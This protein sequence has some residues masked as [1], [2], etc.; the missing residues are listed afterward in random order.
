MNNNQRPGGRSIARRLTTRMFFA[1]LFS[2][3]S[4]FITVCI[5]ATISVTVLVENRA[6][7][8]VRNI[9][10]DSVVPSETITSEFTIT[11]VPQPTGFLIPR[12]LQGIFPDATADLFR[13]LRLID[14]IGHKAVKDEFLYIVY[15]THNDITYCISS[16]LSFTVRIFNGA[17]AVFAIILLIKLINQSI[18]NSRAI[19]HSLD[20]IT[21]LTRAAETLGRTVEKVAPRKSDVFAMSA[22]VGNEVKS[23]INHGKAAAV[24]A[25]GLGRDTTDVSAIKGAL[26]R[27]DA[28]SLDLRLDIDDTQEEL[29]G[30]AAAVNEMLDRIREAY[31]AQIRFV[32]DASHEL[33]TPIAVIQGYANLLD[34]WGKNDEKTLQESIDAIRSEADAMKTLVEQLL[35][36]ARGENNTLEPEPEPFD[37]SD[38]AEEVAQETRLIDTTHE[39]IV[40]AQS[41][42]VVAD[43]KLIKQAARILIDNAVKYSNPGTEITLRTDLLDGRA[44]FSVTDQGEG[45][46]EELLPRIFDRFVRADESRTRSSGGSGLGLAIAKWIIERHDGHLEVL[47]RVG[48]GTRFTVVLP[49]GKAA[50]PQP[51]PLTVPVPT[52][53]INSG[54]DEIL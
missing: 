51:E 5:I 23:A 39:F 4:I 24:R 41:S 12:Q 52:L 54:K 38:L 35:F 46:S 9:R 11:V 22:A 31:S 19:H 33:R 8:A 17:A 18:S 44:V 21:E 2:F 53:V 27:I 13:E 7:V 28:S 43:R 30:L 42:P 26:D 20:P 45:I 3:I 32:S 16:D 14:Q 40:A 48:V 34:R 1:R 47:S 50:A 29:R 10:R 49:R 15:Y 36:L 37:L 6:A 25:V